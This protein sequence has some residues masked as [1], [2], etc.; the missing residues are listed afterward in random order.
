MYQIET[1]YSTGPSATAT[2]YISSCHCIVY[3]ALCTGKPLKDFASVAPIPSGKPASGV[4]PADGATR[5][6]PDPFTGK[7]SAQH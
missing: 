1:V 5:F 4:V 7:A 3:I 2:N 6:G